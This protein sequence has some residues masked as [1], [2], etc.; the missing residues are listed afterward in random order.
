MELLQWVS[1][2]NANSGPGS[3]PGTSIF[4]TCHKAVKLI[5][6]VFFSIHPVTVWP[7]TC[8]LTQ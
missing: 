2:L 4:M 8:S 3:I 5:E 1:M 7:T 6:K